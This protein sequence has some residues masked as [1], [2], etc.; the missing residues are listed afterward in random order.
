[1]NFFERDPHFEKVNG[2]YCQKNF[3]KKEFEKAYVDIRTKEG[4]M[5]DDETVKKLPFVPGSKEWGIRANSAK[6]L[7]KQLRKEN[8]RSLIE[9]GCGNGWLSNYIQKELNIDVCGIDIERKELEQAAR[10]NIRAAFAYADIFSMENLE[11]DVVLLASC[12]QY[13]ENVNKLL[14][15]LKRIGTI[16]II[17]SPFYKQG[18]AAAARQRSLSYFESKNAYAMKN[19]YF[20]HEINALDQ[21]NP[22]FLHRPNRFLKIGSPFPWIR[23]DK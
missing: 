22:V 15:K 16:H 9:I 8:C 23:I 4:R 1:M 17:D 21:F 3:S 14:E 7:I 10:I 19:F 6:K 2:V 18:E 12:I 20:H 5:Y 13:F 11:A